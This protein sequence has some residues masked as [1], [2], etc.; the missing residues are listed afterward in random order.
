M[1]GGRIVASMHGMST[2][3]NILEVTDLVTKYY[4]GEGTVN[5]VNTVSFEVK[6][7]EVLA[8][9]GESG[10][11]KTATM[12]SILGLLPSHSAQIKAGTAIF[13]GRNLLAMKQKELNTIRGKKIGFVFQDP[14]TSLNPLLTIGFQ[15]AEP[16]MVHL[17]MSRND[18]QKRAIELLG[19]VGIPL[20]HQRVNDYP[21]NLSGGMRQRVLIAIALACSPS[22]LIADEPT[23][24]V[25][26]TIQA[27]IVRLVRQLQNSR[28]LSVVWITHDLTLAAEIADRIS[29]MYA[30]HIV[31]EGTVERIFNSPQHPYTISLLN[32]VPETYWS[33]SSGERLESISGAP[34]SGYEE[35]C[36][37][38]FVPRC[39]Y[40]ERRCETDY[41]AT[42]WIET[43]HSVAC[44]WSL[45]KSESE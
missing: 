42:T 44:W 31:E 13:D 20:P 36:G 3:D 8:I 15:V 28:D 12:M 9:V 39:K 43:D 40:S 37:C 41:P 29:V 19:E 1:S 45:E 27:Q 24:A 11:G 16:M 17:H 23:T 22:L 26:V 14:L 32:C 25:D 30:G 34:P 33:E 10:C 4:T 6:R 38:P 35:L 7:K 18:A 2:E 5:A 21:H